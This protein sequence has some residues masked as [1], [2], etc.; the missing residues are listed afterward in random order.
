MSPSTPF[1]DY[2]TL[3]RCP[4]NIAQLIDPAIRSWN[5]GPGFCTRDNLFGVSYVLLL[6]VNYMVAV[7]A[8]Y[9]V[10]AI[11]GKIVCW[12]GF[13]G[14]D[15]RTRDKALDWRSADRLERGEGGWVGKIKAFRP[16]LS[17]VREKEK[18]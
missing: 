10:F 4:M 11:L 8:L 17:P 14:K 3:H 6:V 18:M 2:P 9:A 13:A 7:L 16:I 1:P 5:L 12:R 15:T